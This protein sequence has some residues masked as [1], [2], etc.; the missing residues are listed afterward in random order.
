VYLLNG[1][2]HGDDNM[3]I[4]VLILVII[5]LFGCTTLRYDD[6]LVEPYS[7]IEVDE[8]YMNR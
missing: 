1:Q 8:L 5:S 4:I 6:N 3:K 2:S 7:Q